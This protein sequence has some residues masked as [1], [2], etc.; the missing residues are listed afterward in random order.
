M[1]SHKY[2]THSWTTAKIQEEN[3]NVYSNHES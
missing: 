2:S 3:M 1:V